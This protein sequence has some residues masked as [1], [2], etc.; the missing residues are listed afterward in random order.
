MSV[1]VQWSDSDPDTGEKRFVC[2]ER[3]AGKWKL[4]VRFRRRER[5]LDPP[6]HTR[7]M[8][9]ALLEALE[10]RSQRNEGVT[11]ADLDF[12]RKKIARLA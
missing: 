11:D 6:R 2:A 5:W 1:D 12:V 4:Y 9:E 8:W 10:R 3:F 7:E